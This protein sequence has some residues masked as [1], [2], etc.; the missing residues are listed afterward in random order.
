MP[1]VVGG[2]GDPTKRG[3]VATANYEAR[4]FGIGSGMALRVAFRKCPEAIFLP[5]DRDAYEAA[6]R[7]VMAV[8]ARFAAELETWGWDEAFLEVSGSPGLVARDIQLALHA[9]TGLSCSVGIGDN[10][11]RAKMA[12]SFAKPGGVYRLDESSW[13]AVMGDRRTD[14]LWG[15]GRKTARRLEE[16]GIGTVRQLARADAAELAAVFGPRSGPW[17]ASLAHGVD[18]SPVTSVPRPPRS[19][20]LELT[21]EKDVSDA[22]VITAHVERM[23]HEIAGEVSSSGRLVT[24]V[25]VKVRFA[26]FVTRTRSVRLQELSGAP[27]VVAAAAVSALARVELDRPVRLVGVRADLD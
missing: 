19:R 25:V 2:K 11:L 20:S 12:S 17:L 4:R 3:A 7:R 9:E 27:E 26:P 21:F 13:W 16:M 15:I 22:S 8:L 14:E 10:K 6:S 18:R 23:A 24:A 1:V 5:H